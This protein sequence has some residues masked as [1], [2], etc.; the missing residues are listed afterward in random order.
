MEAPNIILAHN[1]PSGTPLP[2]QRDLSYTENIEKASK[3]LGIR[4]LDHIIIAREGYTSIFSY[5]NKIS[6][7][8]NKNT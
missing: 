5:R 7:C 1:H 2:S 8:N 6:I 4:L 3:L